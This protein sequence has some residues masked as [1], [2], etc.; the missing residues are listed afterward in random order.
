M[1]REVYQMGRH[2]AG[3][4]IFA[5]KEH[6]LHS[7]KCDGRARVMKT[8]TGHTDGTRILQ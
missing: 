1:P 7:S 3:S 8:G 2:S 6:H 4:D 5:I